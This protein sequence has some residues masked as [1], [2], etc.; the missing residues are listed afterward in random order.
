MLELSFFNDLVS[1]SSMWMNSNVLSGSH[2]C[3]GRE[4]VKGRNSNPITQ[5]N[6]VSVTKVPCKY[7]YVVL[8]WKSLK[9][10]LNPELQATC[11]GNELMYNQMEQNYIF[12][13]F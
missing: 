2:P 13:T 9:H 10:L 11:E 12:Y 1:L 5:C 8:Q 7:F 3:T 4:S 6:P